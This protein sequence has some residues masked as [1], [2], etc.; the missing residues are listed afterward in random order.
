MRMKIYHYHFLGLV[1]LCHCFLILNLKHKQLTSF[2]LY[3]PRSSILYS[4]IGNLFHFS[5]EQNNK[6]N[7]FNIEQNN[8]LNQYSTFHQMN[9]VILQS[10]MFLS[11]IHHFHFCIQVRKFPTRISVACSTMQKDWFQ[12]I[13]KVPFWVKMPS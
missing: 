12:G 7:H 8:H 13:E 1:S 3:Q 6:N 10:D 9:M 2:H 5:K 4:R 11:Q